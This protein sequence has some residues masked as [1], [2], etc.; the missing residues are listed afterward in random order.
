[1]KQWCP[2]ALILARSFFLRQA[3]KTL[4]KKISLRKYLAKIPRSRCRER[5]EQEENL[6]ESHS[7][8]PALL[9]PVS[10]IFSTASVMGISLQ[11]PFLVQIGLTKQL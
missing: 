2:C 4:S 3:I 6:D 7:D 10:G 1:M 5:I 9:N 11:S 8:H